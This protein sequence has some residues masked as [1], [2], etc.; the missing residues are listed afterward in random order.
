MARP[1]EGNLID[2]RRWRA[3]PT[4]DAGH[5]DW[6]APAAFEHG[7]RMIAA[8]RVE[9][10]YCAF[11]QAR[12]LGSDFDQTAAQLWRCAMLLGRLDDAWEVSDRVLDYRRR[13]G[14]TCSGLPLHLQWV[15]DGTP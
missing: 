9:E 8:R 1:Y 11:L 3:Q 12:E 7:E 6:D 5:S 4:E 15:W 14:L 2:E 13:R 10:A